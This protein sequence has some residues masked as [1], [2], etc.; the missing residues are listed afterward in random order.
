MNTLQRRQIAKSQVIDLSIA[1]AA[2]NKSRRQRA[3]AAKNLRKS[4]AAGHYARMMDT[5]S[6]P[7][8]FPE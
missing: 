6:Y 1:K 4:M 8:H 2:I 7:S 3:E 5:I